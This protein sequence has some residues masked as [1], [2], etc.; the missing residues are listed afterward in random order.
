MFR[1]VLIL[2]A[3]TLSALALGAMALAANEAHGSE[4]A[5]DRIMGE[6]EGTLTL[7]GVAVKAEAKVIADEDHKYRIV[8][9]TPAGDAKAKRIELNGTGKDGTVA[10]S[11]DWTGTVTRDSLQLASKNNTAQMKRITRK[12]PTLGQKPPAGAIVLLPFEKGKPTNLDHWNN[13]QWVCLDDGSILTRSGDTKTNEDFGSYKLHV[14][15]HVPF[16]PAARGQGRGNSGVYQHGRYEIQVLDSFGLN[17][18]PGECAAI[19]GQKAADLNVSLPPGRWQTYDITFTAPQFDASGN[20][21]KGAIITVLHN[22]VKVHDAVEVTKVTG[23]AWGQPAKTGP[24]RLQDHGN[25][26]RFRN[27]WIVLVGSSAR[28]AAVQDQRRRVATRAIAAPLATQA[29]NINP[30]ML[31]RITA[32]LPDKAPA[33]PAQPRKLLV[34]TRAKGFVHGSIPVAAKAFE[35]MGEKTGAFE[36]VV[37]D[38][39]SA[40][41]ADNLKQFDAVMMDSTTGQIFGPPPPG[42]GQ[43]PNAEQAKG[44][45]LLKNLLDF[46]A[47]GKGICGVHAATDWSGWDD[48]GKMMGGQFA[49][50]PYRNI[51]CKNEDPINPINAAFGGKEFTF[52]DEIYVFKDNY[53]R[54]DKHVLLSIDVEKSKLGQQARKDRDYWVSWVRPYGQGRVFYCSLG[55]EDAT[56]CN[57]TVLKHYLAGIQYAMG[58]LKADGATR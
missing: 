27:I 5:L 48:Y 13:K 28:T 20:P 57:Q 10:V 53:N 15:F 7:D 17:E 18:N 44:Q 24:V 6:F 25:P 41:E 33:T 16:M 9:L 22:G 58:D 23:G 2:T 4:P 47:G 37:S 8:L 43:T 50:H 29:I 14:E 51:V 32:A 39:L 42:H 19:Y 45:A 52:S 36:T 12:S 38:D 3:C 54:K 35:L 34:F 46:V 1:K 40:L 49:Q 26:T 30:D 31:K 56:Y 55:H 11:G 21:V